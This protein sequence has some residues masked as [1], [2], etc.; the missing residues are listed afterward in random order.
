MD[1]K[2]HKSEIYPVKHQIKW[3]IFNLMVTKQ[4]IQTYK[5]MT[6]WAYKYLEARGYFRHALPQSLMHW[7]MV[8]FLG[9]L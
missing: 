6:S 7:G 1:T 4:Q 8:P 2:I 5:T 9:I 3:D